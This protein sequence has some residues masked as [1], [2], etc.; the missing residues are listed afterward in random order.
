MNK[1]R[2]PSGLLFFWCPGKERL[3][4]FLLILTICY[5]G[6]YNYLQIQIDTTKT[7]KTSER[8]PKGDQG[9]TILILHNIRLSSLNLY[10]QS[11]H[12]L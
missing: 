8:W 10:T 7:G 4:C 5:F 6:L 11:I 3:N 9:I 12:L 2:R 1:K